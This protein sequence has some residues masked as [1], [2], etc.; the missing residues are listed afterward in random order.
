MPDR[1]QTGLKR[2][3]KPLV[4]DY[5]VVARNFYRA[6]GR[7]PNIATPVTFNDHIARRILKDRRPIL[8]KFADKVTAHRYVQQFLGKRVLPIVYGITPLP[9]TIP[10][11]LLPKRFVVKPSHASGWVRIVRD[12]SELDRDELIAECRRW[13]SLNYYDMNREWAYKHIKPRIIV[14]DFID[15]GTGNV[16]LDYRFFTFRGI[17]RMIQVDSGR[18][19]DHRR[20]LYSPGWEPLEVRSEYSPALTPMPPPPH[21]LEM[22]HAAQVLGHGIDFVRVDFYDTPERVIFGELTTSPDCGLARFHPVSFD[23]ELGRWWR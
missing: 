21:L 2:A 22:T 11:D 18:F 12:K 15:D 16:P 1:W 7:L 8:T 14:E 19:V 17:V 20:C 5:I 3:V 4:P 10:F 23:T 13:L 9:E 6:H